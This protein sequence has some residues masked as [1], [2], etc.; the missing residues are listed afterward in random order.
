M[1]SVKIDC[2]ASDCIYNEGNTC[3]CQEIHIDVEWECLTYFPDYA[4]DTKMEEGE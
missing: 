4:L 1:N 3:T 2:N